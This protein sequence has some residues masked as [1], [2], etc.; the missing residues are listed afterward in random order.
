MKKVFIVLIL[1][2]I[3][4]YAVEYFYPD[5]VK[6]IRIGDFGETQILTVF[7]SDTLIQRILK[8][9]NSTLKCIDI[10]EECVKCKY[11]NL[12]TDSIYINYLDKSNGIRYTDYVRIKDSGIPMFGGRIKI[13]MTWDEFLSVAELEP[14]IKYHESIYFKGFLESAEVLFYFVKETLREVILRSTL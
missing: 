4:S 11:C 8:N 14:N 7:G 12:K 13:G 9:K 1:A 6:V 5:E 3:T 10:G 2:F